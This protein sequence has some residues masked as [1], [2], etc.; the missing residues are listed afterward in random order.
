M[1]DGKATQWEQSLTK[2]AKAGVKLPGMEYRK[3]S[4]KNYGTG[5]QMSSGWNNALGIG[6]LGLGIVAGAMSRGSVGNA[7]HGYTSREE[8][9]RKAVDVG[10]MPM[11]GGDAVGN[12]ANG[13][14]DLGASG[15]IVFG[16][17][18]SRRGNYNE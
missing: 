17:S 9:R 4:L 2:F 13:K 12:V 3:P 14:R 1:Y 5:L 15:D 8:L 11:M 6:A 16:L 10:P 7:K 18:N